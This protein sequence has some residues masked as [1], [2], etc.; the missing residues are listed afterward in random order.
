MKRKARKNPM[1]QDPSMANATDI[2]LEVARLVAEY[3]RNDDGEIETYADFEI[4]TSISAS[5][6]IRFFSD[7]GDA[8]YYWDSEYESWR[9]GLG[10]IVCRQWDEDPLFV[11]V[12]HSN[13]PDAFYLLQR[14]GYTLRVYALRVVD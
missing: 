10:W 7:L 12:P 8:F 3:Q 4:Q 9:R 5:I 14:V 1:I 13:R 6:D 2:Q 11:Y